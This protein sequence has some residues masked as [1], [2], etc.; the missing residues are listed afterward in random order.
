MFRLDLLVCEIMAIFAND[1]ITKND[2]AN[3]LHI[4][5]GVLGADR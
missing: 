4:D 3:L 5:A 1:Y 2:E